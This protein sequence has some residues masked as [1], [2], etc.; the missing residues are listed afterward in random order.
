MGAE[1]TASL[2]RYALKDYSESLLNWI[3][4]LVSGGVFITYLA[5]TVFA[6][7]LPGNHTMV[8]TV[9]IMA[10]GLYRY[11]NLLY[12]HHVGE[13]PEEMLLGDKLLMTTV[14]IWLITVVVVLSLAR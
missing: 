4:A 6:S 11:L 7:N 1:G 9:P 10:F 2:Q 14:L 13:T 3:I 8:A 5:Y 12:H